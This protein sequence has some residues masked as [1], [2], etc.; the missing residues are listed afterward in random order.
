MTNEFRRFHIGDIITVSTGVMV[1]PGNI[2]SVRRLIQHMINRRL[3]DF[4]LIEATDLVRPHLRQAFAWL[5]NFDRDAILQ[6]PTGSLPDWVVEQ[7]SQYGASHLVERLPAGTWVDRDP[8]AELKSKMLPGA[9]L[10]TMLDNGT[11]MPVLLDNLKPGDIR[12]PPFD[13]E[14]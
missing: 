14:D 12:N 3:L 5:D 6:L 1:S 7:A 4:Q 8:I 11:E 10:V 9:Q 2:S 13:P